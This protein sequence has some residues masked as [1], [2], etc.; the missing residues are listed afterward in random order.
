L[1]ETFCRALLRPSAVS[2]SLD[3]IDPIHTLSRRLSPTLSVQPSL[4]LL[5]QN[6]FLPIAAQYSSQT[7]SSTSTAARAQAYNALTNGRPSGLPGR[8]DKHA[9]LSGKGESR[10][11]SSLPPNRR[12]SGDRNPSIAARMSYRPG[13]RQEGYESRATSFSSTVSI[14]D[15]RLPEAL[16][17]VLTVLGGGVLEGHIKLAAAL[18]RRYDDQ[19]PLVRSLADVFTSHVSSLRRLDLCES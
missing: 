1:N 17:K 18:R 15:V 8:T 3:L 7:S 12:D 14:R 5:E 9:A 10:S 16:E 11:H 19:Y 6:D 2:P 13:T 4:G